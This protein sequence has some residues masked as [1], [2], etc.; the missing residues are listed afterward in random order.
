[1]TFEVYTTEQVETHLCL[2]GKD[3]E[4]WLVWIQDT[5]FWE[6]WTFLTILG[7]RA[8]EKA[9]SLD[10]NGAAKTFVNVFGLIKWF[11]FFST[12]THDCLLMASFS[13]V[14]KSFAYVFIKGLFLSSFCWFC[15]YGFCSEMVSLSFVFLDLLIGINN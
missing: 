7:S 15:R 8:G 9:D 5:G 6:D 10:A 12:V 14:M 13:G 3:E 11:L 4:S 2:K 1:M